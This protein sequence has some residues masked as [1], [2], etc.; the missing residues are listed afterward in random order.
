MARTSIVTDSTSGLS[1]E[2]ARALGIAIIPV[3]IEIGGQTYRENVDISAAEAYQLLSSDSA[4]PRTSPPTVREFHFLFREL[5][6][7]SEEI[8]AIHLSG[9]LGATVN[10]ARQAAQSFVS[11]TRVTVVDSRL[12]ATPLGWLAMAASEAAA[13]GVDTREIV[14]LLRAMTPHMYLAFFVETVEQLR[15]SG[16]SWR[17]PAVATTATAAKPLLMIEEGEIVPLERSRSRGRAV[18]RLYEF[19]TEFSHL[20]RIAI[21]QG[22]PMPEAIELATLINEEMPEQP[23]ETRSYPASVAAYLGTDALGVAVYEGLA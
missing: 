14:R 15:E 2:E 9:R 4:L 16:I 13:A 6:R 5:A 11:R 1:P 22:R 23:V 18:D 19:V 17:A 20:E 10:V 8:L 7:E 12:V 21:L 3:H